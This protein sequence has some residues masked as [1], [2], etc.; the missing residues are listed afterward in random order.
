MLIHLICHTFL[1]PVTGLKV[2]VSNLEQQVLE[3]NDRQGELYTH[4]Y[5]CT[6]RCVNC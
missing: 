6:S 4:A 1:L 2:Q 5:R 3:L